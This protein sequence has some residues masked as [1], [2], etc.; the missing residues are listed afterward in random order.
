MKFFQM[1]EYRT[2]NHIKYRFRKLNEK[3][4][5]TVKQ[6]LITEIIDDNTQ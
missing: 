5:V 6:Q 4:R 2:K 3:Y 1:H